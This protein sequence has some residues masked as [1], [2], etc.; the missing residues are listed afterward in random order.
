MSEEKSKSYTTPPIV[1]L[2]ISVKSS[3]S[4]KPEGTWAILISLAVEVT[5]LEVVEAIVALLQKVDEPLP[6]QFSCSHSDTDQLLIYVV[7]T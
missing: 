2:A 6:A 4:S 1:L 7:K 3:Q 5:I